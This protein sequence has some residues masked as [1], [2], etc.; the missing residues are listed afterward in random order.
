MATFLPRSE[1]IKMKIT[2]VTKEGI[3]KRRSVKVGAPFSE[4]I[5]KKASFDGVHWFNVYVNGNSIPDETQAP[6][7]IDRGMVIVIIHED[8]PQIL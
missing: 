4:T 7:T 5:Y 8:A 2:V 1:E 6:A 3:R